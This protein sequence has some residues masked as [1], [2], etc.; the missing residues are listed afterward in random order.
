MKHSA[1]LLAFF[2]VASCGEGN[3]IWKNQEHENSIPHLNDRERKA[4]LTFRFKDEKNLPIPEAL[5]KIYENQKE[6]Y[7]GK[8]D[9]LGQIQTPEIKTQRD[10]RVTVEKEGMKPL[11][12]EHLDISVSQHL[13]SELISKDGK[14]GTIH[15]FLIDGTKS[16]NNPIQGA[17][18]NVR[19]GLYNHYG[20]ILQSTQTDALGKYSFSQIENNYYTLEIKVGNQSPVYEY[21]VI[22]SGQTKTINSSTA[23]EITEG[24]YRVKLSWGSTPTDMD[25]HLVMKPSSGA[26]E[27]IY[28]VNKESSDKTIN[29]DRDDVD[30]FGP[31]TTTFTLT[32]GRSYRYFVHNYSR[33][34]G[35]E[36]GNPKIEIYKGN[37][38]IKNINLHQGNAVMC[39]HIFDIKNNSIQMIDK[40]YTEGNCD[41]IL[42][43]SL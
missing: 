9:H 31:E 35:L 30:S 15:G 29:L 40:V 10:L 37:Q 43:Q 5:V 19:R 16:G 28:Y 42:Q 6:V 26:K 1:I 7:S 18:I 34:P 22:H 4:S 38:L 21:V 25:S 3:L 32:Q 23:G 14:P 27:L 11:F 12:Y 17:K 20:D 41:S 24:Q 36:A 13:E 2:I 39:W 8:T 33:G